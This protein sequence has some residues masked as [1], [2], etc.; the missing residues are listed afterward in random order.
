MFFEIISF[1]K[2]CEN[3]DPNSLDKITLGTYLKKMGKS[4]KSTVK[5]KVHE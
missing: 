5:D 2:N 1:Y 3:L 4:K